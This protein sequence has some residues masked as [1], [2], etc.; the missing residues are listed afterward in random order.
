MVWMQKKHHLLARLL[1]QQRLISSLR[2]DLELVPLIFVCLVL[3]NFFNKVMRI[4][5]VL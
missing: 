1:A 4:F 5:A 2:F 3:L